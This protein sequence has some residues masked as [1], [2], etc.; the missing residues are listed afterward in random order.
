MASLAWPYYLQI[1]ILTLV[2]YG[3]EMWSLTLRE[4]VDWDNITRENFEDS[5]SIYKSWS[6]KWSY[7][8]AKVTKSSVR[9][10][11]RNEKSKYNFDQKYLKAIYTWYN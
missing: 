5:T 10:H 9:G 8:C 4:N 1:F 11:E 2:L 7:S 3:C 6:N